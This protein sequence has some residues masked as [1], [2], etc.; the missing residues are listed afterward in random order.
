M[1]KPNEDS[2]NR[3]SKDPSGGEARVYYCGAASAAVGGLRVPLWGS[4]KLPDT[5]YLAARGER[6]QVG[7]LPGS[8]L[9]AVGVADD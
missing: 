3:P 7:G 2:P 5:E 6:F 9:I 1:D 8:D 4:V